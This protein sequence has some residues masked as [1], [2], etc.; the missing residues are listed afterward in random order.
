M[1]SLGE[2]IKRELVGAHDELMTSDEGRTY[3]ELGRALDCLPEAAVWMIPEGAPSVV[4][5][6]DRVLFTVTITDQGHVGLATRPVDPTQ[7][8]VTI[9]FSADDARNEDGSFVRTVQWSFELEPEAPLLEI[10]GRLVFSAG[11]LGFDARERFARTLARLAG[12]SLPLDLPVRRG[13]AVR[14]A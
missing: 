12:L 13:P 7:L 10:A 5:V 6:A 14:D 1:T 9:D 2:E 8:R 3:A 11:S 4:A